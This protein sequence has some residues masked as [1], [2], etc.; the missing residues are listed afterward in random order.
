M[1]K[2]I[3]ALLLE[4]GESTFGA[5]QDADELQVATAA[6]LVEAALMDDHFDAEERSTIIR[7]LKA[8]F[9]LSEAATEALLETARA[10]VDTA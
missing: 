6:L 2:R 10:R 7:L 1:I 9:E 4:Q 5:T 8:R 3:K